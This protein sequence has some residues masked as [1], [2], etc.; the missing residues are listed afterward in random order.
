MITVLSPAKKLSKENCAHT[1]T[2]TQPEFLRESETLVQ[3]LRE[4]DSL[5]LQSLMGISDNLSFMNWERY[6]A[7]TLPFEPG[8]AR[9]AFYTFM[10]DTYVG[11]DANTLRCIKQIGRAHV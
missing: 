5:S 11:L 4:L 1:G 6:Q 9:Q 8:S 3:G 10:G 2:F 7:W